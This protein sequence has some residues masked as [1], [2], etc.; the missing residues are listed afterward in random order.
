MNYPIPYG[1]RQALEAFLRDQRPQNP[2]LLFDRY[3]PDWARKTDGQEDVKKEGLRQVS[4]A[5]AKADQILLTAWNARW[6]VLARE[7]GGEPF[8]MQTDWRMIAGLGRKGPLEVGFTFHRYG[9]PTLPGSSVK[10]IARAYA[11]AEL[12]IEAAEA[13]ADF[14]AIFGS[15]PQEGEDESRACAGGAI[16]FDAIP[17]HPPKLELDIMNPHFPAYY[18]GNGAPSDWQSPIPVYFLTVAPGSEFR[19]AVGWR[20]EVDEV[21]KKLR[22]LAQTWLASGLMELGAGAKTSAG[23][24]YFL[25]ATGATAAISTAPTQI[26]RSTKPEPITEPGQ[27]EAE[28]LLRRVKALTPATIPSQ[29][30]D[31]VHRWQALQASS[32]L[33]EELRQAMLSKAIPSKKYAEKVWYR[34]LTEDR[35]GPA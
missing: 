2:G 34:T 13:N 15:A 8:A 10:G 21:A 22:D 31:L 28:D 23:Y 25:E 30:A 33:I 5:A 32:A 18:Q 9:F 29:M 12:G 20:E 1:A 16:F 3:A 27:V 11:Y 14:M 6:E 35:P 7:R 26:G 17:N 19:F 24:G 4:H